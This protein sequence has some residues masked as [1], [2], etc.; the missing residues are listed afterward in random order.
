MRK[1]TRNIL[2]AALLVF[3]VYI[4]F[5]FFVPAY[6]ST[7]PIEIEIP[8]GTPYTKAI[9]ILVDNK[10]IRDK[11]LFI[12]LGRLTGLDK[13]LRAGYYHFWSQISPFDVF[14]QLMKGK[15]IEYDITVV[16]GDS[17]LEVGE[18]LD[19]KGFV[20]A[21]GFREI[22]H[23]PSLLNSLDI[24][25]PSAEGYLFPETYRLP[26]GTR[27]DAIIK[28]MVGKLRDAYTEEMKERMKEM[29]W[30]ENQVL[31]MASIVEKEAATDAERATIA[32]VYYNRLRRHMPLQAD[33]TAIYGVKSSRE[34]IRLSDLKNRTFY[35]TYVIKG[36]PPGPIASPGMKSIKAAL[37]PANVPYLYFVSRGDRTHVFTANNKE[38]LEAVKKVRSAKKGE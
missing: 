6:D 30:T 25:G 8:Q 15:I 24:K 16:E 4:M 33:P 31:T 28:L 13:K 26:K 14:F 7:T 22:A 19:A 21:E 23:D 35:N 2:I 32:G 10:L 37:Y 38:H 1:S 11:F 5:Q 27:P 17:L 34:K 9:D 12:T 3:P 36:L 20:S 29:K 18:K